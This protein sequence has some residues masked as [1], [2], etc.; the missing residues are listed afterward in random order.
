MLR[1]PTITTNAA[2]EV[3]TL[4][5][6]P[7]PQQAGGVVRF[8]DG[9]RLG[10]RHRELPDRGRRRRGRP[11]TVDLGHV[12]PHPG[13][14]RGRQHGRRGRRPLPPLR[15][16]RR[17][18]GRPR[19]RLVSLLARV[20][21]AAARRAGR[22]QRGRRR[23]L[24][25]AHRLAAGQGHPA[26]G[27]AVPLGSPAGAAGRGRLA[28]ARHGRALRRVRR[29]RLR[30]AARPGHVVDDAQRAMGRRPSSATPSDGTRPGCRTPRRRCARRT[31]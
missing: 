31:T 18:D 30:A 13:Q 12:L 7:T 17:T 10:H 2:T 28:R 5:V 6:N 22:A 27:H 29:R 25:A 20:A 1:S 9:L 4:S 15:G 23:L 3:S 24:L 14:D 8:P 26:L 16:G 19:R 11:L 21:A